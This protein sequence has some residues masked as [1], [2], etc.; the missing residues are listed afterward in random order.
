[1]LRIVKPSGKFNIADHVRIKLHDQQFQIAAETAP[2]VYTLTAG[3]G[4]V[5][6]D[7]PAHLLEPFRPA[8]VDAARQVA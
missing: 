6:F 7:V 4:R 3:F 1:M 8:I 2:G 5:L